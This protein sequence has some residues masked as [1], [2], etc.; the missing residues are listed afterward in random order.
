MK[1]TI[2]ETA[3]YFIPFEFLDDDKEFIDAYSYKI[4][5]ILLSDDLHDK[6]SKAGQEFVL[7][8]FEFTNIINNFLM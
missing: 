5:K 2:S 7:K 8:N 1:E 3:G 6:F 4:I